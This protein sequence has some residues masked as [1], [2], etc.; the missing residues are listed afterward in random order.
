M[1]ILFLASFPIYPISGGVQRVTD[2]LSQEFENLGNKVLYLSLKG[3]KPRNN[4]DPR[5]FWLSEIAGGA[6]DDTNYLL[7]WILE[8]DID[9]VINQSGIYKKVIG[10]VESIKKIKVKVITVHH[11]CVSCLNERYREIRLGNAGDS[12]FWLLVDRPVTWKVLRFLNRKKYGYL[13]KEAIRISDK[14]V[15]LSP[16]FIPELQYYGVCPEA[17]DVVAIPNPAPFPQVFE[18]LEEKENRILYVG[19]LTKAQKRVDRLL[20]I[21]KELHHLHPDW[22][23]DVVGDGSAKEWMQ[24]YCRQ[25]ELVRVNFFGHTDPK[26]FLRKAK[27]FTLVSDF[28]GYGMVLV[29]AQAY[30]AVPVSFNCFSAIS[31]IVSH[32]ETGLIIEGFDLGNYTYETASLMRDEPR[33]EIIANN[34]I[35]SIERYNPERIAVQWIELFNKLNAHDKA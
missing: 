24:E 18:A 20:E 12:R 27:L 4:P 22:H 8:N 6:K 3:S 29:E 30:G 9:I 14:L 17:N 34:A 21:W 33:R 16:S 10:I 31:D 25:N 13:F 2:V 15:L 1:K 5:Q 32:E 7:K 19:R 11:N 35:K 23:F 26:P 28:E